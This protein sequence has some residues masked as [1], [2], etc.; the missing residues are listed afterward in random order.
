[1]MS[2]LINR[3]YFKIICHGPLLKRATVYACK[4]YPN[5]LTNVLNSIRKFCNLLLWNILQVGILIY[6]YIYKLAG[7]DSSSLYFY[8]LQYSSLNSVQCMIF[9]FSVSEKRKN[10][11]SRIISLH[12]F[13]KCRCIVFLE[14]KTQYLSELRSPIF[15]MGIL[16]MLLRCRFK[17]FRIVE[18][19][20][21]NICVKE[22]FLISELHL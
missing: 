16:T 15:L 8:K 4:I 2:F 6:I 5:N 14:Q 18:L 17:T 3:P 21:V 22:E 10:R 9:K 13:S 19:T 1:M 7:Q 12:F 20:H 11:L